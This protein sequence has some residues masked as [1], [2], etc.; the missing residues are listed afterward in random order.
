MYRLVS[1]VLSVLGSNTFVER[2][3]YILKKKWIDD[4]NKCS[5]NLIKSEVQSNVNYSYTFQ[6]F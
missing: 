1:Y 3:F 4:R 5:L 2:V 6:H